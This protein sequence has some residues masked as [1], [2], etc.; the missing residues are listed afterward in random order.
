MKLNMQFNLKGDYFSSVA[1]YDKFGFQ[2]DDKVKYNL[3]GYK[4]RW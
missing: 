4:C 2:L 3:N 1:I